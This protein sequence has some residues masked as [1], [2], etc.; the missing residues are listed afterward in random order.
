M[1]LLEARFTVQGTDTEIPF[2]IIEDENSA[3]YLYSRL[4]EIE[5]NFQSH[6]LKE[7][8]DNYILFLAHVCKTENLDYENSGI[9][10]L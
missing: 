3:I 9:K 4:N 6:E 7:Q 5:Y 1:G 2:T 8:Q 10:E